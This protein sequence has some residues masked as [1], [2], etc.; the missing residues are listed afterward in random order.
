MAEDAKPEQRNPQPTGDRLFLVSMVLLWLFAIA[1]L[2]CHFSY[3]PTGTGQPYLV[4]FDQNGYFA[5]AHSL[6][7][8][9]DLQFKNEY[10]FLEK[11]QPEDTA[12]VFR[13]R[14]NENATD[15]LNPFNIGT[16]LATLPVL[17][18]ARGGFAALA[19]A[20]VIHPVSR[21]ASIYPFIF[22]S[23][24]VTFGVLALAC[25]YA[26]LR[27]WF[28]AG[29]AAL[30]CWA[31]LLCGPMLYYLL[32]E[33]A[34]SHLTGAFFGSA[35]LLCWSRW[36]S[37]T[38]HPR[39]CWFA[40]LTGFCAAYAAVVRPYDA[41]VAL[42]LLQPIV[43]SLSHKSGLRAALAPFLCGV[44]G[45]VVG[46]LPQLVAWKIQ[47]GYWIAN[48]TDHSLTW[49]SPHA[50]NVLFSRRHGLF[51]WSP[52]LLL[53]LGGLV[54]SVRH[55]RFPAAWLLAIFVGVAYMAGTW[56][57]YWIGVSFG[58]RSYVD[59]PLPFAFG[60]AALAAWLVQRLGRPGLNIAWECVVLFA[61]INL[62]LIICFRGG[63]VTVDGPLHWLD[64]VSK[65]RRY[66]A[67]LAREAK[68]WTDFDPMHRAN[69]MRA[70]TAR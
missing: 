40:L 11:T 2:A 27:R 21:F 32:A 35:A 3:R 20:E 15:P 51:F 44:L 64:T 46:A 38:Y 57:Y 39:K 53:A 49:Y 52:A 41:P 50:L 28:T 9:Q 1:N 43:S 45:A 14:L 19:A 22:S 8:D 5:Y 59:H 18:I 66:K 67:Q 48:T 47:F 16:G 36:D 70:P 25:C 26:F 4:G 55:M 62:H 61:L 29:T 24:N 69:I 68:Y 65:G 58:M 33:P 7:F 6:L 12:S 10:N 17:A 30:G 54:M 60:F 34:M 23:V 37:A 56:W 31:V 63:I 13:E 42:V